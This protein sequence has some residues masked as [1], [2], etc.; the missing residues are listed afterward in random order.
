M[1]ISIVL[2]KAFQIELHFKVSFHGWLSIK[3]LIL[4]TFRINNLFFI[5][6]KSNVDYYNK[7]ND[8]IKIRDNNNDKTKRRDNNKDKIKKR[9]NN[10][11]KTKII[12]KDHKGIKK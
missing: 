7:N 9:D 4:K 1:Y 5:I 12:N 6:L 8:K 11:D 2:D 3:Q 10:K